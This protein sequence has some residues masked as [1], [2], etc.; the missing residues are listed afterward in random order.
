M[1][2]W[3]FLNYFAARKFHFDAS[4]AF[5]MFNGNVDPPWRGKSESQRKIQNEIRELQN[6]SKHFKFAFFDDFLNCFHLLI[7]SEG[8]GRK[9]EAAG[10]RQSHGRQKEEEVYFQKQKKTKIQFI[11]KKDCKNIRIC[12]S[13]VQCTVLLNC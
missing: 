13:C 5:W 11:H 7:L 10:G 8:P 4:F 3:N 2:I 12:F 1:Q 9:E 6:I